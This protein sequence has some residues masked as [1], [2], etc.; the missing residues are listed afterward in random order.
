VSE[1]RHS[2]WFLLQSSESQGVELIIIK[3]LQ[4]SDS[5]LISLGSLLFQLGLE[6]LQVINGFLISSQRSFSKFVKFRI[7]KSFQLSDSISVT[8][9][10]FLSECVLLG[11]ELLDSV[12]VAVSCS[13]DQSLLGL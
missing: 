5:V 1:L 7:I 8:S 13:P 12:L 4:L 3:N 9:L 6:L 2:I 11:F 10:C